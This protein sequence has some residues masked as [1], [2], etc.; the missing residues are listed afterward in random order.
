MAATARANRSALAE[1]ACGALEDAGGWPRGPSDVD[2][3]LVGADEHGMAGGG[4]VV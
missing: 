4:V 1:L 3:A 2:V